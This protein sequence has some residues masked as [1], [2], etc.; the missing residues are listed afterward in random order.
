MEGTREVHN[1]VVLKLTTS[2]KNIARFATATKFLQTKDKYGSCLNQR[3]VFF[4]SNQHAGWLIRTSFP[5]WTILQ[6]FCLTAAFEK[7]PKTTIFRHFLKFKFV[8]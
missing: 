1:S 7:C 8:S 3:T 2:S 5:T 4:L 6:P